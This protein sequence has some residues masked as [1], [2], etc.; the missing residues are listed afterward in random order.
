ML[1]QLCISVCVKSWQEDTQAFQ[2]YSFGFDYELFA[3]SSTE[4]K[5]E[6]SSF[7]PKQDYDSKR[8][9]SRGFLFFRLA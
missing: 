1:Y 2:S 8:P 3:K 4:L 7:I 9:W 6:G 5:P